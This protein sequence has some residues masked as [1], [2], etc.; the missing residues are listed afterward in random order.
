MCGV[1]TKNYYTA[2]TRMGGGM[3]HFPRE[4]Q[5]KATALRFVVFPFFCAIYQAPPSREL[6][7]IDLNKERQIVDDLQLLDRS[8]R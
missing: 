8:H 5:R 7:V 4:T 1:P 6:F 3:H 2:N